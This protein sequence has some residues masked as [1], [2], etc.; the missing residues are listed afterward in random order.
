MSCEKIALSDVRLS[1]FTAFDRGWAV[2]AAGK[3]GDANAM[4]VSWGGLGTLWSKPVATVYVRPQR[5]T[6][7]LM[8]REPFYTLSLFEGEQHKALGYLGSASGKNEDKFAHCGLTV[9]YDNAAGAPMFPDAA[10]VLVCR[11]LYSDDIDP[12]RVADPAV[13][14]DC[15][16]EHDY[17]RLYI[18]EVVEAYARR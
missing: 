11:K 10:F 9:R 1:S 3:P 6:F 2:L 17:H 12:A 5:F 13:L 7:G 16:P 15:Y 8:E 14:T 4:T 18:G